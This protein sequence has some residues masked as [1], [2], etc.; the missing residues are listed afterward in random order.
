MPLLEAKW[1]ELY[2]AVRM[3]A[4][5]VAIPM[6]IPVR[7]EVVAAIVAVVAG[8]SIAV[9]VAAVMIWP[10]VTIVPGPIISP[11]SHRL[12]IQQWG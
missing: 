12:Q 3:E 1:T 4:I 8:S 5:A 7:A 2:A 6:R 9:I 11:N 10:V